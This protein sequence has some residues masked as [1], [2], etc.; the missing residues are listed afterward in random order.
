MEISTEVIILLTGMAAAS[1]G[2]FVSR[3]TARVDGVDGRVRVLERESITR[4]EVQAH[5]RTL[6]E[7]IASVYTLLSKGK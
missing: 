3:L 2:W 7:R 5:F 1:F 6:E 4:D